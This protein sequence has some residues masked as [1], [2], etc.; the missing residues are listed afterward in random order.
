VTLKVGVARAPDGTA[1]SAP[2]TVDPASMTIPAG[3]GNTVT[4]AV[5]LSADVFQPGIAYRL[6]LHVEGPRP[7]T[8]VVTIL[9][10]DIQ[11]D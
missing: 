6:P 5:L 2:L 9:A 4:L 10:T 3:G 7:T 11:S 1:F 8:V